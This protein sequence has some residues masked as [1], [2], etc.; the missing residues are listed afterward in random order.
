MSEEL[1]L[2]IVTH[3]QRLVCEALH[4]SL[5]VTCFFA[6]WSIFSVFEPISI[7]SV[8]ALSRFAHQKLKTPQGIWCPS[9]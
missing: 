4:V 3:A 5:S 7:L 1:I 8:F 6:F 2:C 9:G